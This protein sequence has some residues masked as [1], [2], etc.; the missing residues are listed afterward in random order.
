[1][2]I[3]TYHYIFR[4]I[5][6]CLQTFFYQ[7]FCKHSMTAP[8]PVF[9][10]V[11]FETIDTLVLG[12]VYIFGEKLYKSD[13]KVEP[14]LY[15]HTFLHIK[16]STLFRKFIILESMIVGFLPF[17]IIIILNKVQ[18]KDGNYI[19]LLNLKWILFVIFYVSV[20]AHIL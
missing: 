3:F 6:S 8:V 19:S 14:F 4:C 13:K 5:L 2:E 11:I 12:Q 15:Y 18:G 9:G 1:M 10:F 7:F 20:L 16:P 17:C